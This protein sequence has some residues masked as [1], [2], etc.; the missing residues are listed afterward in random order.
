MVLA[1]PVKATEN[2]DLKGR[3]ERNVTQFLANYKK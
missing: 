1:A 2:S 3:I